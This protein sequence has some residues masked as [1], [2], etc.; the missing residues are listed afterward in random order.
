MALAPFRTVGERWRKLEPAQ[1][2]SS[3]RTAHGKLPPNVV[4]PK[5]QTLAQRQDNSGIWAAPGAVQIDPT[6]ALTFAA[7]TAGALAAGD[8]FLAY[9]WAT[10]QGE[11]LIGPVA[12]V[13]LLINERINVNA[14]PALPAGVI[15]ANI[16]MSVN[17]GERELRRIT[18]RVTNAAFAINALPAFNAPEPPAITTAVGPA[19][20]GAVGP[21][22]GVLQYP[23]A[24]DANGDASMGDTVNTLETKFNSVE[25]YHSGDFFCIDLVGLTAANYMQL[26]K[27][28]RGFA[29][30]DTNAIL[31]VGV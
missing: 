16:Y 19:V 25:I 24:T 17:A 9:S 12:T 6:V 5:G 20:S 22:E 27:L 14:L 10:A 18:Q 28:V 30:T 29:I 7:N 15:A 3:A 31:R 13:T 21:L 23:Y 1:N 26:G 4:Y 11:T 2:P 8:Y